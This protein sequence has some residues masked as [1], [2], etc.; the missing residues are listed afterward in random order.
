MSLWR[1]NG[2]KILIILSSTKHRSKHLCITQQINNSFRKINSITF[3][4][5]KI[6]SNEKAIVDRLFSN[7][8]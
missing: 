7:L 6:N 1:V 4:K 8:F 5:L 2:V 3:E